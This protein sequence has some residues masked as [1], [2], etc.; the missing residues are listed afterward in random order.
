MH[1]GAVKRTS[2]K[3]AAVTLAAVQG[4]NISL[5]Q[6]SREK[7][8]RPLH[9]GIHSTQAVAKQRNGWNDPLKQSSRPST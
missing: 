6:K 3:Q 9:N 5:I 2:E 4:K 8:A 7:L 1:L